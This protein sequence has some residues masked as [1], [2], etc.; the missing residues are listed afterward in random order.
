M[1]LPFP[2]DSTGASTDPALWAAV[3]LVADIL[4]E[5]SV[6]SE[7][8]YGLSLRE[9]DFFVVGE[10]REMSPSRPTTGSATN[11]SRDG[12][13]KVIHWIRSAQ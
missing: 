6:G 12:C 13:R 2:F 1:A 8:R 7:V 10:T 3:P 5:L 11:V 9:G 4:K